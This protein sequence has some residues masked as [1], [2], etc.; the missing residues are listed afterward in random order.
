MDCPYRGSDRGVIPGLLDAVG[1][2]SLTYLGHVHPTSK[3]LRCRCVQ[4]LRHSEFVC[5][6]SSALS[7]EVFAKLALAGGRD[8]WDRE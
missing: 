1:V 7:F 6:S 8:A 2:C 4:P 5:R 3:S